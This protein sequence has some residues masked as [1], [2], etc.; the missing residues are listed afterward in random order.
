M[1]FMTRDIF[2]AVFESF[3]VRKI[4]LP[5]SKRAMAGR[6]RITTVMYRL[7]CP[8][9]S[10]VML[11]KN[12]FNIVSERRSIRTVIRSEMPALSQTSSLVALWALSMSLLPRYCPAT[13]A[14]PAAMA[15]KI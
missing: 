15:E 7:A 2:I 4:A 14:P 11:P 3:M 1:E 10:S 6:D 13:I 5:D 12:V 8:R 9:T